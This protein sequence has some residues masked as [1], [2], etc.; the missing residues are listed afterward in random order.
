MV[1]PILIDLNPPE[2]DY[3]PFTVSPDKC[4]GICNVLSSKKCVPKETKDIHVKIFNMITNKNEVKTMVKHISCNW[5]CA[6]NSTTWNSNQKWNNKTCQRDCK[7]YR[8]CRKDYS[9]NPSRYTC[10]NSKYLRSLVN[11]SMIAC[12]EIIYVM[13]QQTW[14]ILQQEMC[15]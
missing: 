10:E 3:Y 11:T 9:W 7:N 15:Q 1:R 4:S 2:L 12:N 6:F 14:P 8:N 5:K 13:D